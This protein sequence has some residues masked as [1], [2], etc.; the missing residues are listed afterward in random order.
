MTTT[1]LMSELKTLQKIYFFIPQKGCK[2]N[3]LNAHSPSGY[4]LILFELVAKTKVQTTCLKECF[5]R[6]SY[7]F[8][9]D[10]K[11]Y[12]D[13]VTYVR[14][15]NNAE[16]LG[17]KGVTLIIKGSY[18]QTPP[19]KY[20]LLYISK[21]KGWLRGMSNVFEVRGKLLPF[22]EFNIVRNL[23][24]KQKGLGLLWPIFYSDK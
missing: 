21:Y 13:Y 3:F 17:D 24:L 10:F 4:R 22:A 16:D 15:K 19:G 5:Y 8:Q 11:H 7:P 20:V 23:H 14:A 2:K 6:S 1:Q 18:L 12:D 9:A